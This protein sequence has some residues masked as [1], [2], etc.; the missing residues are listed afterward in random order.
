MKMVIISSVLVGVLSMTGYAQEHDHHDMAG[1]ES[2]ETQTF[3]A[4][5]KIKSIAEDHSSI[6][7]FHDPIPELKW[8]AMTMPFQIAD[9]E[10]VHGLQNGDKISFD[11]IRKDGKEIIIKIER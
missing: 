2:M 4:T 5:G 11:F 10:M 9:H 3:H 7:V 8:P 6:R 1:M